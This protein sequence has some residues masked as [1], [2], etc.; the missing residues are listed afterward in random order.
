LL[1]WL[2]GDRIG[3]IMHTVL[4]SVNH[5]DKITMMCQIK[6]KTRHTN[7]NWILNQLLLLLLSL[8]MKFLRYLS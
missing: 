3:K 7:W 6:V 4:S 2:D 8:S 1:L 5:T